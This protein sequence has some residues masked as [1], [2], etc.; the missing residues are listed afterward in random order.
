M[1]I[2]RQHAE[3][4][5]NLKPGM[6]IPIITEE[7]EEPAT[8]YVDKDGVL[9]PDD[10]QNTFN[11]DKDTWSTKNVNR[12]KA[13]SI[14]DK[15][16]D[17]IQELFLKIYDEYVN[18]AVFLKWSMINTE[19]KLQGK[20]VEEHYDSLFDSMEYQIYR[21]KIALLKAYAKVD[22]FPHH[23]YYHEHCEH[24]Q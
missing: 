15:K 16:F 18:S 21:M 7:I 5:E 8:V 19:L 10:L 11:R 24:F 3:L 20:P 23:W 12:L 17:E 6:E 14:I 1:K 13:P 2:V 22:R 9:L 4:P